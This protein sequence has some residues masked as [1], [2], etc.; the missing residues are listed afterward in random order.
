MELTLPTRITLNYT[1]L[2]SLKMFQKIIEEKD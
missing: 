1:D 2:V